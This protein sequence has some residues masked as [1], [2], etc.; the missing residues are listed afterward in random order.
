MKQIKL[1]LEI[2]RTFIPRRKDYPPETTLE[3]VVEI[4]SALFIN[5]PELFLHDRNITKN[6]YHKIEE[7][8]DADQK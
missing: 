7:V 3:Q 2:T 1:T 6:I 4:E 8:K 5:N